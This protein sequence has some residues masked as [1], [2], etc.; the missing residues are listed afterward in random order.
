VVHDQAKWNIL[1]IIQ[2]VES[3]GDNQYTTSKELSF[4]SGVN[5]KS[6][7]VLLA[8]WTAKKWPYVERKQLEFGVY[9][10]KIDFKGISF[11]KWAPR[12]LPVNRFMAELIAYQKA[13][14]IIKPE[15]DQNAQPEPE[16]PPVQPE[17]Q[18]PTQLL[19]CSG[20]DSEFPPDQLD[21]DG[22][23]A[24]CLSLMA[25]SAPDIAIVTIEPEEVKQQGISANPGEKFYCVHCKNSFHRESLND[26]GLCP[27]CEFVLSH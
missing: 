20:C 9:G 1:T 22:Y 24:K 16:P 13:A 7:R 3:W 12:N 19:K 17:Q 25:E 26:K 4:Y 10:Y 14:G 2:Q 21:K 6:L 15:E 8:R 11:L 27:Y 5:I 23:C 18:K